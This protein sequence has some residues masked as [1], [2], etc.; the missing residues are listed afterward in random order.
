[1]FD[2]RRKQGKDRLFAARGRRGKVNCLLYRQSKGKNKL[3]A[4]RDRQGKTKSFA[5][6]GRQGGC[7]EPEKMTVKGCWFGCKGSSV[8]PINLLKMNTL[9][10]V[11]APGYHVTRN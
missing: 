9:H 11:A 1:M 2:V 8:E 7:S 3:F 5:T 4:A 10:W 6:R